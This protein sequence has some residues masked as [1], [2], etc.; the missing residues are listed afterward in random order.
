[1]L[2]HRAG[3]LHSSRGD[4]SAWSAAG[5]ARG[6]DT[7]ETETETRGFP[8]GTPPLAEQDHESREQIMNFKDEHHASMSKVAIAP[9][10]GFSRCARGGSRG[11][12]GASHSQ[13][14]SRLG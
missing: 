7:R 12:R 3:R 5:R 1:M 9:S 4:R 13:F 10:R 8:G 2:D 14:K 6:A 11:L